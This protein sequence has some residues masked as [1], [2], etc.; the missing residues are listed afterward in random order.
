ML[1][2][3]NYKLADMIHNLWKL[4]APT[5]LEQA[6]QTLVQYIDIAMV[7]QIGAVASAAVG[8]TLSVSWMI[9]GPFFA[10]GLGI[11]A[12]ISRSLGAE[13]PKDARLASVQSVWIALFLGIVV[14]ALAVG[15]SPLLPSWMG[16]AEEIR[17]SASLYFGIV[18]TPMIFR[19]ASI[20]FAS[21]LRSSGDSK[22]PMVVNI[23]MNLV[24]ICLN[25]LLIGPTSVHT[26]AG[27]TLKVWGA[28][29]GVAGAA[30]ATAFAYVVG[31]SLMF[32]QIMRNPV[33]TLKG[34]SMKLEPRILKACF[35][36]GLPVLA[37]RTVVSLGQIVFTSFV[38]GLGT[39]ATA[40]HSIALIAEEA[41]YVP[42]Y[43]IQAAVS[44]LAGNALG[45]NSKE[46][47]HLVLRAALAITVPIMSFMALFMFLIP[48]V[49]IGIFSAD[50]QV[51]QLGAEMLRIIAVSEPIFAI[52]IV[53]EGLF[54]GLGDTIVPFIYSSACIWFVRVLWTYI[55]VCRLGYGL[56]AA[57]LCMVADNVVRC[58][59]LVLRYY[60][61]R[62]HRYFLPD[63]EEVTAPSY[64]AP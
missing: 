11:L 7:G 5:I 42:G 58:V 44:T 63:S 47:F 37:E 20:I 4:G 54:N 28:G 59:L 24:N 55:F 39:I 32:I 3:R 6:F 16:A 15:V 46:E 9:N 61:K 14:G 18:A 57:W 12:F 21:V 25:L 22:S 53:M 8:L 19:S 27:L 43:G 33:L 45:R 29:L 1:L 13:C 41:I 26:V 64:H 60:R 51:V 49:I 48:K 34:M 10:L 17:K 36:I 62:W 56:S 30:I 52:F 38:A 23:V 35:T 50:P 2:K 40:A 31:G